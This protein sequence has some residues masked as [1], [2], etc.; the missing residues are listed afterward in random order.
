MSIDGC[1]F[2]DPSNPPEV[3]NGKCDCPND[4]PEDPCALRCRYRRAF[5]GEL[6]L[7]PEFVARVRRE[8]DVRMGRA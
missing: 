3:I 5:M 4:L 8:V 2:R 7:R 1:P 6:T